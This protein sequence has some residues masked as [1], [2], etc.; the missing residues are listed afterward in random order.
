MAPVLEL[1]HDVGGGMNDTREARVSKMSR[2]DKGTQSIVSI[3]SLKL[4]GAVFHCRFKNISPLT[5]LDHTFYECN[6]SAVQILYAMNSSDSPSGTGREGLSS[7][8]V[9]TNSELCRYR[10]M[11]Q[12]GS[13]ETIIHKR[14][15]LRDDS[16]IFGSYQCLADC[17][18]KGSIC[19]LEGQRVEFA[20]ED[21]CSYNMCAIVASICIFVFLISLF[22]TIS[23]SMYIYSWRKE[24]TSRVSGINDKCH[25]YEMQI[26]K[27]LVKLDE[28]SKI[29]NELS[30]V[31]SVELDN[32][33][34][35]T[36]SS[37]I[38]Q[39]VPES[40]DQKSSYGASNLNE[41]VSRGRLS[42]RTCQLTT[43]VP[44]GSK[45]ID[46]NP[47][48]SSVLQKHLLT[49]EDM[50][51]SGNETV[52]TSDEE[53]PFQQVSRRRNKKVKH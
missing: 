38:N 6:S 11:N 25:D 28:N 46:P 27:V 48:S 40:Q 32:H 23:L 41:H 43:Q 3:A 52:V 35:S 33:N 31:D 36:I 49:Q 53:K 5:H 37:S 39:S 42:S 14:I 20:A 12:M 51:V 2:C 45:E 18:L 30:S 47:A 1:Y 17:P 9:K 24:L 29:K 16:R 7:C 21:V 19:T 4:N 44:S 13:R 15:L 26:N 34:T 8:S 10:W 50:N 22:V